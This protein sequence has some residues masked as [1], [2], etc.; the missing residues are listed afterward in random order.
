[1]AGIVQ[2]ENYH[3]EQ[4]LP[5]LDNR[6]VVFWRNGAREDSRLRPRTTPPY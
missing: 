6:S 4:I 5:A 3:N 2:D 1:M